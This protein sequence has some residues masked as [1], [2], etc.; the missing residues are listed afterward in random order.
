MVIPPAKILVLD[1]DPLIRKYLEQVLLGDGH[2]VV[3]LGD[4]IEALERAAVEEFDLALIDLK[5]PRIGGMEVLGILRQKSPDT[6]VIVLT[7]YASLNTSVEALRKGAHDYLLKP[8][9]T[10]QLRESVRSGLLKRQQVLQQRRLLSQLEQSM[11]KSLE[12]LRVASSEPTTQQ[13][14]TADPTSEESRFLQRGSL[15]VDFMRHVIML[16]D[17]LLELSPTEFDL[18]AYLISEA[19]RVIS[20]QELA[21]E[22]QGY[23]SEKWQARDTVR[24]HIYRIRQKVRAAT[25]QKDIIR[26]V[27]GVGYT[28]AD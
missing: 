27:R 26:T 3:S 18:M 19:P 2:D 16:E 9:K 22:V 4:G 12:E 20:P 24:Y 14:I 28:I 6:P 5:M 17:Q 15:I 11:S 13:P 23:E 7:A 10:V 1:D 21:R 8:C 25:E